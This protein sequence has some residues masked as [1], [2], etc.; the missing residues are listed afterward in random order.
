VRS[1]SWLKLWHV[2]QDSSHLQAWRVCHNHRITTQEGQK[3]AHRSQSPWQPGRVRKACWREAATQPDPRSQRAHTQDQRIFPRSFPPLWHLY[4]HRR[5][6]GR[7]GREEGRGEM[8][9]ETDA[10]CV[11]TVFTAAALTIAKKG[12]DPGD[13]HKMWYI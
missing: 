7:R 1:I 9:T 3:Q 12:N 5:A 13:M 8:E 11:C 10:A 2:H 6:V 4:P